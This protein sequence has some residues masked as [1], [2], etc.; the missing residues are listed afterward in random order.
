MTQRLLLPL[1]L[2]GLLA[3]GG[4]LYVSRSQAPMDDLG[5]LEADISAPTEPAPEVGGDLGVRMLPDASA[6]RGKAEPG[7]TATTVKLPLEIDIEFL[8]GKPRLSSPG[9]P[10]LD[11]AATAKIRGSMHLA[12]GSPGRGYAEFVAGP[13]QG[14]V[15]DTDEEGRFG[16][17]D[18]YA[19]LSLVA[20]RSAG[21][22]GALREVVLRENRESQLNVGFGRTAS[23]HGL[24]KG[25]DNYG[26]PGAKVIMDGQETMTDEEG[27]FYFGRMTS[28]KVPI[29]IT[30][31]GYAS[32]REMQFITGGMTIV[33]GKLRFNL[34]KGCTL[35]V[36]IP[37]RIGGPDPGQLFLTSSLDGTA[38]RSYPW[39]LKSPITV[40][41]GES[42]EIEDLPSGAVYL[43]YFKRGTTSS[44]GRVMMNLSES[45]TKTATIHLKAA[46]SITGLVLQ[47]GEPV[48]GA[49]VQ[50]EMPDV[51]A[52]AVDAMGGHLGRVQLEVDL[53]SQ[54]PPAK[55]KMVTKRDGRFFFSAAESYSKARYLTAR[56]PDGTSWGGRVVKE[57]DH[58]V[59]VVLD[60]HAGGDCEMVFETSERF[61][62]IPVR[63]SVNGKPHSKVLPADQD[64][65]VKGLREGRYN[66]EVRWRNDKILQ[67]VIMDVAGTRN[68]FLPLP[69]GAID[70]ENPGPKDKKMP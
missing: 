39:H 1:L 40:F 26:L 55:Q 43:Q 48:E 27:R 8:S 17:N 36:V 16:A 59:N 21:T 29:Y 28:G 10:N 3:F 38:S 9:A 24:V 14:R 11:S 70:G 51:S 5:G 32:H 52:A 35:R 31:P 58:Q 6:H 60:S 53:Y 46:P 47:D 66:V 41:G 13:N 25:P 4:Y 19:G 67:D 56:G 30:K 57:G 18:L 42:I 37:E 68:V 65:T 44:P 20:L 61:Q 62:A 50:L 23:V 7:S 22:P 64:L 34:R 2:L 33:P 69:K 15:L 63:Y 49:L 12:D 54:M 45:V